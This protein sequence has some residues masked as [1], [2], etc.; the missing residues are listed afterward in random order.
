M[1]RLL[2]ACRVLVALAI[3][4]GAGAFVVWQLTWVAPM[5]YRPADAS[6]ARIVDLA[7]KVEYRLLEEAQKI[8]DPQDTWTLRVR[9]EQINAW[10]TTRLEDWIAHE[11]QLK[12][13]K[14]VRRPQVAFHEDGVRLFFEV[15]LPDS[16]RPRVVAA[17]V[18]PRVDEQGLWLTVE[19]VSFGMIPMRGRPI[20]RIARLIEQLAPEGSIDRPAMQRAMD[21]LSGQQPVA[22]VIELADGR[23]IHILSMEHAAGYIDVTSRTVSESIAKQNQSINNH[24]SGSNGSTRAIE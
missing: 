3:L 6:D 5:E 7:E 21:L 4:V 12:L 11:Q 10:L 20:E 1:R 8:R 19:G 14:S 9:E 17:D 2:Y 24:A 13:P 23:L 15:L 22:S 16:D 18:M